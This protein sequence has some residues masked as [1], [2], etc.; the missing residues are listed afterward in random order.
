MKVH[1]ETISPNS[2]ES[3]PMGHRCGGDHA[4][5]LGLRHGA[6]R[7]TIPRVS[8]HTESMLPT[9]AHIGHEVPR[10]GEA[11]TCGEGRHALGDALVRWGCRPVAAVRVRGPHL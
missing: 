1:E 8:R 7:A 3:K 5:G 2:F 9:L 10:D 11:H 4:G 6:R